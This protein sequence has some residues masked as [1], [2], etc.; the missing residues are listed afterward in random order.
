MGGKLQKVLFVLFTAFSAFNLYSLDDQ[1]LR[2]KL[3]DNEWGPEVRGAE[4]VYWDFHDSGQYE[5]R[6]K[7]TQ[8]GAFIR[9]GTFELQDQQVFLYPKTLTPNWANVVVTN[10]KSV[11][12]YETSDNSPYFTEKLVRKNDNG[13]ILIEY[14]NYST[15]IEIGTTMKV[16][17]E[18]IITTRHEGFINLPN[19]Y[20]RQKP[21][22]S[23][24][25]F[26]FSLLDLSGPSPLEHKYTYFLPKGYRVKIIGESIATYTIGSHTSKW[27]LIELTIGEYHLYKNENVQWERNGSFTAW[28]LEKFI[29]KDIDL[30]P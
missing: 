21:E 26:L 11:L 20:I 28:T 8:G 2:S 7:S 30:A 9:T 10:E 18:E 24:N 19:V 23:H 12:N 5:M 15:P 13:E 27:V 16:D 25:R 1:L 14:W 4:G 17:D 29:T 3:I 6:G 22:I